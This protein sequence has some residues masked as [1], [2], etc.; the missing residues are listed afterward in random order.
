MGTTVTSLRLPDE[1]I[2]RYEELAK[3][4]R[5]SRNWLI[6]GTLRAYLDREEQ[7]RRRLTEGIAALDRDEWIDTEAVYVEHVA[8]AE[9]LG[10]SRGRTKRA[11]ASTC[12]SR[13]PLWGC[14]RP[15]LHE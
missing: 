2:S 4:S 13:S 12:G 6:A 8:L 11:C 5:R 1:L 7:D 15:D 3:V 14:L 10:S 9:R